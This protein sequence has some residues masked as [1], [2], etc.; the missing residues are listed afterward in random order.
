MSPQKLPT[1]ITTII[2]AVVYHS[3]RNRH[4]ENSV[5]KNH[6]KKNLD[7]ILSKQP[8]ALVIITGDLTGF[9]CKD[10]AQG[11]HFR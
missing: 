3:T 4:L 11:N 8:N 7:M 6:I 9:K 2:L 1:Q 5:L 10:I